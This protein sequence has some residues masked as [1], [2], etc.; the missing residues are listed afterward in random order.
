MLNRLAGPCETTSTIT[1]HRQAERNVTQKVSHINRLMA[2]MPMGESARLKDLTPDALATY[3]ETLKDAGKSARTWNFA[4]QGVLAFANWCKKQGR[5]ERHGLER[6]PKL[7]ESRDRRLER[8]AVTEDELAN[9]FN[10]AR[11]N[12]RIV[13]YMAAAL[14]GL[15]RGDLCRLRWQDVDFDNAVLTV[16]E[17]KS[18]SI[19]YLSLHPQ[20]LGELKAL[21]AQRLATPRALVFPT[22][23]SNATRKADFTAAGIPHVDASGKTADLHS[24]RSTLATRLAR[25]NVSP[26]VVRR[27]MRHASYKTTQ[28]HYTQLGLADTAGAIEQLPFIGTSRPLQATGTTDSPFCDPDSSHDSSSANTRFSAHESARDSAGTMAAKSGVS[29]SHV[30]SNATASSQEQHH[31][32]KRAKG[33]E[34]STFSLEG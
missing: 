9:L 1:R 2:T 23:V 25:A 7:D 19:D 21:H 33:F 22:P 4:R 27:I 20:L 32:P 17:G 5:L 10:V 26:E 30:L 18:K 28:K 34:P 16:R 3:L 31:A 6:V 15:R 14:A 24:L 13:W 11:A 8:R 29:R 12:G